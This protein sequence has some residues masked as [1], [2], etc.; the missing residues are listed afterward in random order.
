[1]PYKLYKI[2]DFKSNGKDQS[3]REFFNVMTLSIQLS[4]SNWYY[5]LQRGTNNFE[6]YT[7][8]RKINTDFNKMIMRIVWKVL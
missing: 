4:F 2:L 5:C 1:M 3:Q 7:R 6:I 8:V